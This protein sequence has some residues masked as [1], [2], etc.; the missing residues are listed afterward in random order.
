MIEILNYEKANKNKII[1]YVDVRVPKLGMVIRKIAHLQ[2]DQKKWFNFP[3]F[4]KEQPD[5]KVR[6]SSYCQFDLEAHNSQFFEILSEKV[7]E[8]CAKHDIKEPEP[9]DLSGAYAGD[10]PF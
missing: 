10:L 8:Y 6:Y 2:S 4:S 1:G 5:G 3:T 9:L 7:K